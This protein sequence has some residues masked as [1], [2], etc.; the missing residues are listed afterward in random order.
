[1]VI[2]IPQKTPEGESYF[3]IEELPTTTPVRC[4]TSTELRAHTENHVLT[5]GSQSTMAG[6][7]TIAHELDRESALAPVLGSDGKTVDEDS[8]FLRTSHIC[9]TIVAA[10]NTFQSEV[11]GIKR[12]SAKDFAFGSRFADIMRLDRN[13]EPV[14]SF[15]HFHDLVPL[16]LGDADAVPSPIGKEKKK[17][18]VTAAVCF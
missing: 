6:S 13:G 4:T 8:D 10:D 3:R 11:Q 18:G 15:E 12:Y 5:N 17:D 14:V 1:M 9:V 2:L 7:I 16:R